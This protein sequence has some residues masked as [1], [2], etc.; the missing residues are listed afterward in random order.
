[1]FE[2]KTVRISEPCMAVVGDFEDWALDLC[3][4][5]WDRVGSW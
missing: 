3:G 2:A 1:M 4:W 5:T